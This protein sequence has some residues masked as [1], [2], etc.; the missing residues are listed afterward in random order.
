MLTDFHSHILPGID[1]GSSSVEESIALLRA[2]AEQG[3]KRV[4]A[5]PHFFASRQTPLTFI[6]RRDE[7]EAQLKAAISDMEGFPSLEVG[8][9]VH[10]FRGMSESELLPMLTIRGTNAILIEMPPAPWTET[11]FSELEEIWHKRRLIPILA[12]IERYISP[13]KARAIFRRLTEMPL[14][15][16]SNADFFVERSTSG[17]AI[18]LLKEDKI[19]LLGSDCHSTRSRRP[20][21]GSAITIIENKL[22]KEAFIRPSHLI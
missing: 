10:F 19:H 7:A 17:L 2:E 14:L 21:M 8:A 4:V 9:E 12:H 15:I 20:N 18:K 22:G 3:I 6:E 16:Q 1:D 11:M 5:T 13:L